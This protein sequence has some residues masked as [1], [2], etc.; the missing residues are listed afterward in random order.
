MS[1]V[2]PGK[3]V[4]VD[5]VPDVALPFIRSLR[6]VAAATFLGVVFRLYRRRQ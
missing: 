3:A 5:I 1:I 4:E 2:C 6:R